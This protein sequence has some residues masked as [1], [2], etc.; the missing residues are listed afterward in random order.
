M[1]YN[2]SMKTH[3]CINCSDDVNPNRWALGFKTCLCCGEIL[4]RTIRHTI[5]PMHKS[6]YV[7]V[8]NAADLVGI[9]S[10]GGIV[11]NSYET[12]T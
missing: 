6:N 12:R 11:H 3:Y 8:F 5:V 7:P 2:V 1:S 4:A 10:K 9:N